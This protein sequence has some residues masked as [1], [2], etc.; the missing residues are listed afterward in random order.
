MGKKTSFILKILAASLFAM[1]LTV[2]V[3]TDN[4]S[5]STSDAGEDVAVGD[6]EDGTYTGT[7]DGFNGP[8]EVEVTVEGGEIANVEVLSHSDSPDISDPAFE[9]VPQ[10]IVENNSTDVDVASGATMS[11]NGIMDAVNNALSGGSS[12]SDSAAGDASGESFEDGTHTG[13]AEGHNGP[14]EVE[15]T[16]ENGE[17]TDVTVLE[18]SETEDLSDPAIEEVPAAIVENNSTDVDTVSGATV[19]SEA[20]MAAV[21]NAL[22]G[23]SDEAA[24]PAT[25]ATYEDGTYTASVEGHNGPLE[26]EV[27]IVNGEISNVAVLDH[28]ETEGLADPAIEEVPAAIVENNSTD[29]DTVS[30]AT[31]TSEAIMDAVNLALEEASG[32]SAA[33]TTE[34]VS[35]TDGTYE[36]STEAHNG[37]LNVEVTIENGEISDVTVLDHSETEGLADPAIEEVPAA[38]VE[39]NSTDVDTVSGATVTSEAIMDAVNNALEA[40]N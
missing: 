8:I 26:V 3:M 25:G 13:T 2:F 28:S 5:L 33:D 11:S 4:I 30:G 22:G 40:A 29:V 35:Y 24:A 31:V 9:N 23:G 32:G 21:E 37:P 20:I 19:T 17:I 27:T 34:A 10:A 15:V 39:N 18:H 14:L 12:G 1:L 6:V 16:V 7:G 38:I 36:G